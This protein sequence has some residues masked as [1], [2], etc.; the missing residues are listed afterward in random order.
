MIADYRAM[1]ARLSLR[2]VPI[3]AIFTACAVIALAQ[4]LFAQGPSRTVRPREALSTGS[5]QEGKRLLESGRYALA[6]RHFSAAIRRGDAPAEVYKLRGKAF[7]KSGVPSRAIKDYSRSIELNPS[8]SETYI[9]RGDARVLN[10][11]YEAAVSDYSNAIKSAPR[12]QEAYL[13]RGLA[14]S[15]MAKYDEAIKDYQW[16]LK[17]KPRSPET[18][19][20]MGRA[21]MLAGRSLEAMTYLEKALEVETSPKWRQKIQEWMDELLK[22]PGR[23]RKK[24]PEPGVR[25]VPSTPGKYW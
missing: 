3:F 2:P 4:D 5:V 18:L 1:G 21:C 19:L 7:D 15:G 25:P 9:L 22:D 10:H 23:A 11:E 17:I 20:N 8:D 12:S 14:Y 16:V 6:I 24:A 13:G